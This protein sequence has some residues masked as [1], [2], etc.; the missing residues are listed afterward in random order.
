MQINLSVS[1]RSFRRIWGIRNGWLCAIHFFVKIY[2]IQS[3]KDSSQGKTV[4]L[5]EGIFTMGLVK[6]YIM[7]WGVFTFGIIPLFLRKV[8]TNFCKFLRSFRVF[9]IKEF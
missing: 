9:S 6:T 3:K 2:V 1:E 7:Y 5:G 4:F 8:C